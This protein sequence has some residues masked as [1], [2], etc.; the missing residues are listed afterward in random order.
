MTENRNIHSGD[1]HRTSRILWYIYGIFLILSV[2]IIIKIITLQTSWEP[3]PKWEHR[4]RPV[5]NEQIIK[6]DKGA[7]L[8]HKGNLL[9]TSV[10]KYDIYMD[11]TVQK[12]YYAQSGE[13]GRELESQ[14]REKAE[15]LSKGLASTLG[16]HEWDWYYRN[17][18]TKRD[19]KTKN[20][21][22]M[23]FC[24]ARGV[25]Y[26]TMM[27]IRSLPLYREGRYKG[28]MKV[29]RHESRHFPY[30]DLAG[31]VL[32]YIKKDSSNPK[33]DRFIG[34]EGQY[35]YI[36]HGKE[37]IQWRRVTDKRG[38][39]RDTD[40]SVV[41]VQHGKDIRTTLDIDIQDIADKALRKHL[42]SD[43]RIEAACC[44]ILDVETGAVRAM[45]NLQ[46]NNKGEFGEYFNLAIGR[47][48][49]PGSIFKT[50][51]LTT[52]I[53]DGK[54]R[55]TSRI[56]TEGGVMKDMPHIEK[57]N[58]ITEYEKKH[59]TR[60]I[61]VIDGFKISSNYV[62][63]R[64]V[65]DH[66]ETDPQALLSRLHEYQLGDSFSF[67]LTENGGG[68]SKLPSLKNESWKTDLVSAAIGYSVME[69]PLQIVTFY[70]GLANDG[71]MM[72]PYLIESFE[73]D[74]KIE[75]DFGPTILNG[76]ICSKATADTITRA[77]VAVTKEGTGRQLKNAKCTVAGK[78]GTARVALNRQERGNS[79]SPYQSEHGERRYQATF[80]GYFPAEEP[81]YTAIITAYTTLSK[82]SMYGGDAP[83]KAYREIVDNLW[84][85]D[86]QWS[87]ELKAR[88]NV[89]EMKAE[90]I[91]TGR[92]GSAPVPDVKGYGLMDAIYAIEN[93]GYRCSYEGMGHVVSQTPA[94]G[95]KGTKGE[96]VRIILK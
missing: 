30:E 12:D 16:E 67:D 57:D 69:T 18:I 78:T 84:A 42:A 26:D 96:T 56:P 24:I 75:N 6:P 17:I 94:A 36:L 63:R 93:N 13:K 22:R 59:N 64:L 50:A 49:E 35:D 19:S 7:I 45:V 54:V 41:E 95:A 14:W 73:T 5:K 83:A 4:F 28:G 29:E 31:R 39:I 90:Y 66:Y 88:N 70:N 89:P 60:S 32:G 71:K 74:G 37:G 53:E 40:S 80:V 34:I 9:V 85:M 44:V 33:N 1:K 52:L 47:P 11:C 76:S 38:L 81:E 27:E 21:G 15:Q 10:P 25:N 82:A 92:K 86:S 65:K 58:Y 20:D 51:I 46:R 61:P 48:G 72:K 79:P 43:E 55:L 2:V 8:D 62:F 68:R 91:G 23:N 87:R 77:L 3:D